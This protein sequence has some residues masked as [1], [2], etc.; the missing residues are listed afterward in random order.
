LTAAANPHAVVIRSFVFGL[1]NSKA[2]PNHY[3]TAA[4]T[5]DSRLQA[6]GHEVVL[7]LPLGDGDDSIADDFDQWLLKNYGPRYIVARRIIF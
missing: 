7:P 2:Y 5:L 4:K 6:L 3:N 1:G